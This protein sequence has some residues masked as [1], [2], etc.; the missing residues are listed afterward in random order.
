M[1]S[2]TSPV[3][4]PSVGDLES[5]TVLTDLIR[6]GMY[7]KHGETKN[8]LMTWL[9][10]QIEIDRIPQREHLLVDFVEVVRMQGLSND[11]AEESPTI[12]L[13]TLDEVFDQWLGSLDA[14]KRRRYLLAQQDLHRI[15]AAKEGSHSTV[16]CNS[17]LVKSSCNDDKES[18]STHL[19]ELSFKQRHKDSARQSRKADAPKTKS[20]ATVISQ[21]DGQAEAK[22]AGQ[23][24]SFRSSPAT[25]RTP[26]LTD[27]TLSSMER[28]HYSR[29][30]KL[31]SEP[32]SFPTKPPGS[33]CCKRCGETG[34]WLQHCPTNLNPNYGMFD[35]PPL[36][37]NAAWNKLWSSLTPNSWEDRAPRDDYKCKICGKVGV[38]FSTLCPDNQ[39]ECSLI[40]QRER[41]I[42][43]SGDFG[44]LARRDNSPE[45]PAT[46]VSKQAS[47]TKG[48]NPRRSRRSDSYRPS[49]SPQAGKNRTRR[50]ISPYTA[51]VR[52][53]KQLEENRGAS[54]LRRFRDCR[55]RSPPHSRRN[56][57][58]D[59]DGPASWRGDEGRLVYYDEDDSVGSDT[60]MHTYEDNQSDQDGS[61]LQV[62]DFL[63]SVEGELLAA[64]K[65][66]DPNDLSKF[67]PE[68]RSLFKNK[69]NWINPKRVH[70]LTADQMWDR[71][72]QRK[73]SSRGDLHIF[74]T[75]NGAFI[76]D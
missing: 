35:C 28:Q 46:Q 63:L 52:L 13:S 55:S 62:D 24:F 41:V 70:R 74:E 32:S 29:T 6:R 57:Y 72:D 37:N 27:T 60:P 4:P 36:A 56:R 33:Y 51:R 9:Q 18:L 10:R 19:S 43:R 23:I 12:H 7:N 40:K 38:H 34:H 2:H 22:A 14:P 16:Q 64:A 44:S 71:S 58:K 54:P 61:R 15:W 75:R 73:V 76:V 50:S 65:A 59:L 11:D 68:V 26:A 39:E 66:V 45:N 42:G 17:I 53:T 3:Y 8:V 67:A 21:D 48:R 1:P 30:Y 31:N 69:E 25:A 5:I 20:A 49:S 47:F